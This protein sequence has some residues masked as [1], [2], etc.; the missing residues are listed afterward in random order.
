M[1]ESNPESH[2][3]F[4][5]DVL[6]DESTDSDGQAELSPHPAEPLEMPVWV[7]GME[8]MPLICPNCLKAP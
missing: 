5:E 4:S 2:F 3:S 8:M 1:P 6:S 7:V